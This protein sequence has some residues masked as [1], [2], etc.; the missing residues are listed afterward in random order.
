M[1]KPVASSA[2]DWL[3]KLLP[4]FFKQTKD[5][6]FEIKGHQQKINDGVDVFGAMR[7]IYEVAHKIS[8][9]ADIFGYYDLGALA[10]NVESGISTELEF[11][12]DPKTSW[13]HVELALTL[14]IQEIE[15]TLT[16]EMT[17]L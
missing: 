9:T 17:S 11:F 8:G 2:T 12:E 3:S 14:L 16:T 4:H 15:K 10:R 13:S 6:L 5:R 1:S 7:S